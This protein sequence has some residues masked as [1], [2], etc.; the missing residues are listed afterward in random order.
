M[1]D[2]EYVERERREYA[3]RLVEIERA[4]KA[5]KLEAAAEFEKSLTE[6]PWI[7]VERMRWMLEGHCGYG[8]A[9][10]PLSRCLPTKSC[11]RRA[12]RLMSG[13]T[14]RRR[15]EGSTGGIL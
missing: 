13:C 12:R 10:S 3:R 5:D 6:H 14:R 15:D 11:A 4:S 7:V 8:A 2:R 1:N 9:A